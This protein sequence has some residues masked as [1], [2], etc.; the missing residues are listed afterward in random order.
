VFDSAGQLA[1]VAL[2]PS[3]K[4]GKAGAADLLVP[5]SAMKVA[6]GARLVEPAKTPA[7]PQVAPPPKAAMDRVYESALKSSLQVIR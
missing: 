6:L 2:P 4:K 3:A 5:V 1:G 7:Q